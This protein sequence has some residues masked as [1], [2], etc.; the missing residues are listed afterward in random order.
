[1]KKI[2]FLK[3]IIDKNNCKDATPF[4]KELA[5]QQ[6]KGFD[7]ALEMYKMIETGK[8]KLYFY[9]DGSY[10]YKRIK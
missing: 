8:A 6:K 2:K 7:F 9:E 10:E 4:C 3:K 5:R 1:M